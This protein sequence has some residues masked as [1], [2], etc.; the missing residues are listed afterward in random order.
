MTGTHHFSITQS[1]FAALKILHSTHSSLPLP[2]PGN[3]P[4][5]YRLHSFAFSGRSRS[6]D[7]SAKPLPHP[8]QSPLAELR[9]WLRPPCD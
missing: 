9:A 1:S 6:W 8:E 3:H 2:M 5:S 4:S 7:R